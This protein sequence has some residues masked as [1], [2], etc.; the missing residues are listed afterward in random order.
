M[1]AILFSPP[2]TDA[3]SFVDSC[4]SRF[5]AELTA[6]VAFVSAR[7]KDSAASTHAAFNKPTADAL[8]VADYAR[9]LE[10][11]TENFPVESTRRLAK[12]QTRRRF[13]QPTAFSSSRPISPRRFL[14]GA[15]RSFLRGDAR[16]RPRPTPRIRF[17]QR[18]RNN[19]TKSEVTLTPLP[20]CA[21][22][23]ETEMKCDAQK[24]FR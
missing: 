9:L 7:R 16:R 24:R 1:F 15:I 11:A 3:T 17:P 21:V 18:P 14:N 2:L 10:I 13:P 12:R 20:T 23:R 8:A 19:V 5:E 4:V 22:E 6:D